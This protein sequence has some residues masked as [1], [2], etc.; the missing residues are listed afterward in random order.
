MEGRRLAA[1]LAAL[2]VPAVGAF[3]RVSSAK[4]LVKSIADEI[5]GLSDG[6]FL[7]VEGA[8]GLAGVVLLFLAYLRS[9]SDSPQAKTQFTHWGAGLVCAV[10]AIE[11]LKLLF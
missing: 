7:I 2:T 9:N 5:D 3:A 11:V 1:A 6:V 4:S 8:I 10:A